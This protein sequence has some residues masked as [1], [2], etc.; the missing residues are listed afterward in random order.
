MPD[1]IIILPVAEPSP[2][3]LSELLVEA[4]EKNIPTIGVV[5]T[6]INPSL[7]SY[8]IPGNDDHMDGLQYVARQLIDV[9]NQGKETRQTVGRSVDAHRASGDSKCLFF[10]T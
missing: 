9:I 6:N 10:G 8:P 1:L 4:A 2:G 5:D 3:I 7:I